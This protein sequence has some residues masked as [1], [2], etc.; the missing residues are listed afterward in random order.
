ML[1]YKRCCFAAV[2]NAADLPMCE[3]RCY[4][5]STSM[6]RFLSTQVESPVILRPRLWVDH[7]APDEVWHA[8]YQFGRTLDCLSILPDI[9][10]KVGVVRG[11]E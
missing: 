8:C 6:S 5:V 10:I 1:T 3:G 4:I 9:I 7:E 11:C 2:F